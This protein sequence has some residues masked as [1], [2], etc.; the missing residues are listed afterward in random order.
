MPDAV[1]VSREIILVHIFAFI[2]AANAI[3]YAVSIILLRGTPLIFT[4]IFMDFVCVPNALDPMRL[5][6]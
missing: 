6:L 4:V 2:I 5:H 3:A 1:S